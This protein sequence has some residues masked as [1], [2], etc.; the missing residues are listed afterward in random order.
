MIRLIV[1]LGNK[2]ATYLRTRHN[3]GWLF[4]ESLPEVST[5]TTWQE[6]FH[7]KW[8]K[9]EIAQTSLYLAKPMTYMN[10]SGICVG[11]MANYFSIAPEEILIVHDDMELPFA[12][13]RLQMGGGLAGH[14][15][16]RSIQSAIGSK[17]FLRLR[18]GI[19][20]PERG[21]VT[22]YVLGRFSP[23][24][25]AELPLVFD[26]TARILRNWIAGKCKIDELP[27]SF[28]LGE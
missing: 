2:G 25:E 21:D 7:G 22:S 10:E 13:T 14:K 1:F 4:L 12:T 16:L 5:G 24:E 26:Q 27:R 11:P 6:K 8:T 3:S 20:R 18:V 19:G 15:G 9:A 23:M 17:N 28:T